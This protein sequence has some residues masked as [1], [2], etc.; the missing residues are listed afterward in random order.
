MVNVLDGEANIVLR[1]NDDFIKGVPY[2]VDIEETIKR[3]ER[4]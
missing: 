3:V 1:P 2:S 4:P